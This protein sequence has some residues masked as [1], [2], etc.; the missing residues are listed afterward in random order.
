MEYKLPLPK[1]IPQM[2]ISFS[3]HEAVSCKI[4]LT[5]DLTITPNE[6]P[7]DHTSLCMKSLLQGIISCNDSLKIL[8]YNRKY[9][10]MA[11]FTVL[12]LLISIIE[13]KSGY[14]TN[15]FFLIFKVVL[16]G[17]FFFLIFMASIWNTIERNSI[18]AARLSMELELK[19]IED[20]LT[21]N[22]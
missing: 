14:G 13:L 2:K 11:A 5:P 21:Q 3:D 19:H 4:K 22:P 1:L 8:S 20:R 18:Y 12:V 6:L 15:T 17:I 9:Y 16:C 10:T 7:Y